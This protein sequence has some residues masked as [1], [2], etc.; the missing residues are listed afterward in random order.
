MKIKSIKF[1]VEKSIFQSLQGFVETDNGMVLKYSF[2]FVEGE[3]W[4]T[5]DDY[6]EQIKYDFENE[7][8]EEPYF[9]G[10][11]ALFS[12]ISQEDIEAY[13]EDCKTAMKK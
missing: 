6:I 4:E 11:D 1:M 2:E 9:I 13:Y 5:L 7:F 10:E 12:E 3:D 8:K